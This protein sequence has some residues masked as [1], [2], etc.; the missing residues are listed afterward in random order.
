MQPK[1]DGVVCQQG[2]HIVQSHHT[3]CSSGGCEIARLSQH[4]KASDSH[5]VIATEG[6]G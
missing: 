4:Y 1:S 3:K 2:N 6:T 5:A